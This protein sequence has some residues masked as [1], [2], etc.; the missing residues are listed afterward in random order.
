[1]STPSSALEVLPVKDD[2]ERPIPTAWRSVFRDVVRA[3]VAHDYLLAA[4]V[5][6]VE[7]VSADSAAQMRNAVEDY[8]AE[9]IELPDE[10]WD[11][12]VCVWYGTHWDVLVDLWSKAE[13]RSDLV[14]GARVT[15]S[16][17][18]FTYRIQLVYVP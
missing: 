4:G 9:L 12:S 15:E 17:L 10:T 8:G 1:M 11:S 7:G 3:F 14:L 5:P 18:G 16:G 6:G 13:G 2:S